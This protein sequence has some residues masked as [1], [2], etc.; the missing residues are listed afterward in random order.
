MH[1]PS[2]FQPTHMLTNY[3]KK[4]K[5]RIITTRFSGCDIPNISEKS[6]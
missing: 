4:A 2:Q 6:R 3:I 5:P 1:A